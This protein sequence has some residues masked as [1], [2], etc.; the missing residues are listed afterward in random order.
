MNP[1]K[2]IYLA[3]KALAKAN[4]IRQPPEKALKC[5]MKKFNIGYKKKKLLVLLLCFFL[6]VSWTETKT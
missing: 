5:N 2:Y 1:N 3:N 6:L 4:L